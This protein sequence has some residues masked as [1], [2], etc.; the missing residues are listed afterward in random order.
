MIERFDDAVMLRR[1][2][3]RETSLSPLLSKEIHKVVAGEL[4]A[5]IGTKP[6]DMG[7]MLCVRPG[8]ER[9][10]SSERFVLHSKGLESGVTRVVVS[11]RDIVLATAET[12]YQ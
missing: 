11:K 3:R 4:T 12:L 7:T 2:V 6:F 8:R 1:I 10:V 9:L 5:A